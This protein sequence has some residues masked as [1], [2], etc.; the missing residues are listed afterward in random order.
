MEPILTQARNVQVMWATLSQA[1]SN[2]Y[3]CFPSSCPTSLHLPTLVRGWWDNWVVPQNQVLPSI[4]STSLS[5][6]SP[7]TGLSSSMWAV[8]LFSKGKGN[9]LWAKGK[10]R[11]TLTWLKCEH[12]GNT[13]SIS[14]YFFL[15]NLIAP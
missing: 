9:N 10:Q 3:C 1:N 13:S 4:L 7:L 5:C 11:V 6:L 2:G 14:P 15:L 8:Q 12:Y